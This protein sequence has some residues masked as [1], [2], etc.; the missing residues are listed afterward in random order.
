MILIRRPAGWHFGNGCCLPAAVCLVAVSA[1]LFAGAAHAADPTSRNN[2]T[3]RKALLQYPDADADR[4]GVLTLSEARAYETR[5]RAQKSQNGELPPAGQA[6]PPAGAPDLANVAYGPYRR[7]VL[8]LWKARTD[9]PAPVFVYFHGGGFM[10]GDKSAYAAWMLKECSPNGI[11]FVSADYRL[12]T[13]NGAA[14]F[15]APML[16][17]ARVIQ[18]LRSK[19][20]EW[21]LDPGR[22]AIGGG[23]AG[24]NLSLWV[25]LHDDLANPKAEDPV[26]RESSRVAC[27]ISWSGQTSNDPHFIAQVLGGPK[28]DYPSALPFYGVKN[29]AELETPAWRKVVVEASAVTHASKDDPP[30]LLLYGDMPP[31]PLPETADWGTV[32]HHP[33]FGTL[34]KEKLDALGVPCLF[35]YRGSPQPQPP[36]AELQFL[37]K[38]LQG[39]PGK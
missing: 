35:Y 25:A 15:P 20:K 28:G 16:D 4:D 33:A 13:G 5:L 27:V 10:G 8:D 26:L 38:Y 1:L 18:F 14:P 23:S 3:L 21:N 12:V 39:T 17:G 6:W 7:N 29:R 32:I 22:I 2:E 31:V 24:A 19:A 9:K 36:G 30:V 34:L 37:K 11:A